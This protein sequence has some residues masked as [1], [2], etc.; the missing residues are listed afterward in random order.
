[1]ETKK[2]FVIGAGTMGSG[3]AQVAIQ[4]G[5]HVILN[6]ISRQALENAGQSIEKRLGANV[7]KGKITESEKEIIFNRLSIS[8]R[9]DTA[10]G[11]DF[12]IEAIYEN[13]DAK[14]QLYQN[15]GEICRE[16]VIIASNTSS[17]SITSLASKSRSPEKFIG[18]HFFSPV[19]VMKLLEITPGFCTSNEVLESAKE[20]GKAFEKVIIVSKD[21]PGFIVNRLLDPMLNDAVR[22][23]DDG[24][25]SIEDIDN[26]MKFGCNHPMGPLELADMAGLDILL[27]V[28]EVFYAELGDP[29]YCPAALLR[30]MVRAGCVGKKSGKGFYIYDEHGD[31]VMPNPM[32]G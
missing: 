15:L 14:T 9:L 11:A 19:P 23:L 6:D 27:A 32:I 24:I 20:I 18:M 31:K 3:I 30:K 1:M 5:Y 10:A 16:D 8:D 29:R 17:F 7:L 26:G 13:F 4:S 22:I 25:G 21:M 2:I 12:V 28:M